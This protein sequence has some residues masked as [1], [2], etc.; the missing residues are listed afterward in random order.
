MIICIELVIIIIFFFCLNFNRF[1]FPHCRN[2]LKQNQ[3]DRV[4]I[5]I[6]Y[7]HQ[8]LQITTTTK[9][10]QQQYINKINL[11]S[12]TS[13]HFNSLTAMSMLIYSCQKKILKYSSIENI[14]LYKYTLFY[15][16]QSSNKSQNWFRVMEKE[17]NRLFFESRNRI[18]RIF[19]FN[20]FLLYLSSK[21]LVLII[22]RSKG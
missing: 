2:K 14:L 19:P 11:V 8:Q 16:I 21:K 4:L 20:C 15:I 12:T 17:R 5:H 18:S 6:T 9:K 22:M 3:I 13:S 10:N 1:V 7:K